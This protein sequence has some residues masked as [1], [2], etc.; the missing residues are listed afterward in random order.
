MYRRKLLRTTYWAGFLFSLHIA[1][2]IFINSSFLATK[3]P[4]FLIGALYTASAILAVVGLYLVPKAIN[5]FGTAKTLGLLILINIGNLLAL[6]LV[7]NIIALCVCFILYFAINTA[8]YLGT[9]IIVEHY[10][11]NSVQGSISG[12]YLTSKNVGFVIAPLIAGFLT[13]RLG[14]GVVYGFSILTLIPVLVIISF[15]LPSITHTHA[16]KANILGLAKKF[17]QHRD[18]SAVFFINFILQ[19][20]YAWMTIYSPLYL[21]ERIG[22]PWDTLGI[23]FTVMLTAF[24]IFEYPLGKLADRFHIEKPMMYLGLLILGGG[25]MLITRSPLLSLSIITLILFISRIGASIIEV[26]T[27]SYFFKK[28][29]H[30]DT[31]SIGF[32]RNTYPFAYIL[33][34]LLAIPILKFSS[35]WVLFIIL[36]VICFLGIPVVTKLQG[37][38]PR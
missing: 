12:A 26:M 10:T 29:H 24:V 1:L 33:A 31:G 21:H 19:F 22:I 30:D 32:F 34:P 14:F 20:F 28:V 13:D 8:V 37:T 23:I 18:F 5:R 2:T 17:L 4:E 38:R 27:E 36:G 25:T 3:I 9:D 7:Q 15:I 6:I 35:L 11:E 16:S